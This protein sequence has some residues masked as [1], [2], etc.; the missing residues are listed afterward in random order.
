MNHFLCFL[1]THIIALIQIIGCVYMYICGNTTSTIIYFGGVV[2]C[3]YIAGL[4][5]KI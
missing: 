5:A 3:T 2:I 1:L 4:I